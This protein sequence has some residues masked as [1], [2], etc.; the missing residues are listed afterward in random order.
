MNRVSLLQSKVGFKSRDGVTEEYAANNLAQFKPAFGWLNGYANM[1]ASTFAAAVNR[2][3]DIEA[4][5]DELEAYFANNGRDV[6]DVQ[7]LDNLLPLNRPA[8]L[9]LMRAYQA[10]GVMVTLEELELRT[11]TVEAAA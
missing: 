8:M 6:Y 2:L 4:A 9:N 1:P 7:W 3:A 11:E 5:Q 10:I